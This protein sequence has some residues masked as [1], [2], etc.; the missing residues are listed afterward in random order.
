MIV[1]DYQPIYSLPIRKSLTKKLL[2]DQ[3]GI[4][5]SKLKSM[6]KNVKYVWIIYDR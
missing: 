5:C 4:I 3:F 6:I 2:T 1:T